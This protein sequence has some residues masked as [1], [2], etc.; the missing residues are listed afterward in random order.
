MVVEITL[1]SACCNIFYFESQVVSHTQYK[2]TKING[3]IFK[4]LIHENTWPQIILRPPFCLSYFKTV[5]KRLG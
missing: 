3:S 1:S 4:S 2:W 5:Q